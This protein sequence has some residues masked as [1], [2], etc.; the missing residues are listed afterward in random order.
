MISRDATIAASTAFLFGGVSWLYQQQL[1]HIKKKE[2]SLSNTSDD[3]ISDLPSISIA[4]IEDSSGSDSDSHD[5][6]V[7][8]C[9]RN[10]RSIFPSGFLQNPPPLDD[11][12]IQSLLDAAIWGPF[13]GKCFA[14]CKHPAKFVVLGKQSMVEMQ[15]MTLEYYDKNWKEVGWGDGKVGGTQE[16]YDTWRKM[17]HDEIT[18]R[19]GPCSH[20]IAIVMRR[21]SG[22]KRLPEWE[23]AAAVAAATQNMHLQSTKFPQLACYWSSWHAAA[24]DSK[25]M[26]EFLGMGEED[27]CLG[28]FIVAQAK[29][30][31]KDR[32]VRD[33]SLLEVEWRK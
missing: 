3:S 8:P 29:R 7:L 4:S 28:F 15:H 24:R 20:M 17:T 10:R 27:K 11:A 32:R 33:K 31:S 6:S 30:M 21:Q 22:P 18:G 13:H 5:L 9:I 12:I 26:K 14:G 16:E 23:E 25:E 1:R 2:K 19:W